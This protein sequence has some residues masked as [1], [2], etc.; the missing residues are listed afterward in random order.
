MSTYPVPDTAAQ[1]RPVVTAP[2]RL[3]A[4][5]STRRWLLPPFVLE[6]RL[7]PDGTWFISGETNVSFGPLLTGLS[8]TIPAEGAR[9]FRQHVL[10]P[11]VV[12][13]EEEIIGT[14]PIEYA[15]N[16]YPQWGFW[17]FTELGGGDQIVQSL[18]ADPALIF[19]D[20]Q[21]GGVDRSTGTITEDIEHILMGVIAPN[22]AADDALQ[23]AR[24]WRDT[25]DTEHPFPWFFDVEGLFPGG[26]WV[27]TS[28]TENEVI[29]RF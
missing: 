21:D 1:R 19:D 12:E 9:L 27:F 6:P 20:N 10:Q 15:T 3:P 29:E 2:E 7:L 5:P 24:A 25:S 8:A 17:E 11:V 26:E 16:Y 23:A 4:E 14:D 28:S 18:S 22:P 13:V